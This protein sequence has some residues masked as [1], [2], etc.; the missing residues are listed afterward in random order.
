MNILNKDTKSAIFGAPHLQSE[1][2]EVPEWGV[3][4]IVSEMSGA[5]RDAFYASRQDGANQSVSETQAVL[6]VATVVDEAGAPVFTVDDIPQLRSQSSAVLDRVSA[7]AMRLNG[8][9]VSAVE[10]AAKNSEAAESG[11]SG[12]V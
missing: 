5:S 3:S 6:L 8:M 9:S 10:D 12:S 1:T 11:V 7:V 4:L 2:V